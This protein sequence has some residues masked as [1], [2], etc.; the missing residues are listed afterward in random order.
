MPSAAGASNGEQST[1]AQP[2]KAIVDGSRG[3]EPESDRRCGLA[4]R[5]MPYTYLWSNDALESPDV[6]DDADIGSPMSSVQRL[7]RERI[8]VQQ[9]A[10]A[11]ALRRLLE[12]EASIGGS[13]FVDVPLQGMAIHSLGQSFLPYP[14][15]DIT[16]PA[17]PAASIDAFLRSSNRTP[18]E[19]SSEAR[20]AAVALAAAGEMTQMRRRVDII[21]SGLRALGQNLGKRMEVEAI[22]IADHRLRWIPGGSD[23]KLS[24]LDGEWRQKE[25]YYIERVRVLFR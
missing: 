6:G 25:E 13:P 11:S 3:S 24:D 7:A 9:E 2:S 23:Q 10:V 12:V 21:N 17:T 15:R 5:E 1:A 22:W 20:S 16:L 19:P 8:Q 4:R 14:G 18:A